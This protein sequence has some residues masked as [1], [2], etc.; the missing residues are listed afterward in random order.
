VSQLSV[1]PSVLDVLGL[2]PEGEGY[3]ASSIFEKANQE[4]IYLACFR[5]EHCLASVREHHKL[6]YYSGDHPPQVYDLR[7]DPGELKNAVGNHKNL[8][9][10]WVTDLLDWQAAVDDLHADSDRAA[11]AEFVQRTPPASVQH[12][13]LIHFSDLLDWVGFSS[14]PS[15][16]GKSQMT[17]FLHV[18]KPLPAGYH[19]ALV[20]RKGEWPERVR[21]ELPVNGLYSYHR[22][23][24]GEYIANPYRIMAV[25]ATMVPEAC[26]QLRDGNNR[27]IPAHT[28]GGAQFDCA[29]LSEM[30]GA[31]NKA[32]PNK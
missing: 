16:E 10:A 13:G 19:L 29:P 4:P 7:S 20:L 31:A 21:D 28:D 11:L 32:S 27:P 3:E 5:Q 24:P 2:V 9:S 26:L 1:V 15:Q 30:R 22:W 12:Q 25:E 8:L 14:A 6:I 23:K 18:R 17:A